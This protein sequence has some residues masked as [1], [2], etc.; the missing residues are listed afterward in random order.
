MSFSKDAEKFWCFAS[1]NIPDFYA[2]TLKHE[3]LIPY[4]KIQEGTHP[5][6]LQYALDELFHVFRGVGVNDMTDNTLLPMRSCHLP[7]STI[8]NSEASPQ[9]PATPVEM[10]LL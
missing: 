8:Q 2:P 6:M 5:K 4:D 7:C 3:T 9:T 1:K 10:H